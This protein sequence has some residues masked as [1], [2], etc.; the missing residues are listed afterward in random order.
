MKVEIGEALMY[1]WVRHVR[2]CRIAQMNWRPSLEWEEGVSHTDIL[3]EAKDHFSN[4]PEFSKYPEF[5]EALSKKTKRAQVIRQVECD[6]LAEDIEGNLVAIEVAMHLKGLG[7][8]SPSENK[9]RVIKK[10]INIAIALDAF[11]PNKKGT[12]IFATPKIHEKSDLSDVCKKLN[13]FF[14]EKVSEKYKVEIIADSHFRERIMDPLWK[15]LEN[16]KNSLSYTELY[17]RACLVNNLFN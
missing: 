11:F 10:L 16:K 9:A 1:A 14:K 8:G 2:K 13:Q 7:Y 3:K 12:L 5:R 17:L 6:V 4:D 15:L